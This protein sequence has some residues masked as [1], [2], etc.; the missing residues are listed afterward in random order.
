[1]PSNSKDGAELFQDALCFRSSS[2]REHS[3]RCGVRRKGQA[4]QPG[5]FRIVTGGRCMKAKVFWRSNEVINSRRGPTSSSSDIGAERPRVSSDGL[6]V[7]RRSDGGFR[8]EVNTRSHCVPLHPRPSPSGRGRLS[9]LSAVEG[10][11][12]G[13]VYAL[14][15]SSRLEIVSE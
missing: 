6:K 5:L 13:V 12:V 7:F 9:A 2:G 15:S 8:S 1:M 11:R 14:K 3:N 10:A 4:E